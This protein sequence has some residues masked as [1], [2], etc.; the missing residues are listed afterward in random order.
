MIKALIYTRTRFLGPST[1]KQRAWI[2]FVFVF[3]FAQESNGWSSL[4]FDSDQTKILTITNHACWP[5]H[6]TVPLHWYAVYTMCSFKTE[7]WISCY[8]RR[9]ILLFVCSHR[10][11]NPYKYDYQKEPLHR[12]QNIIFTPCWRCELTKHVQKYVLQKQ[13]SQHCITLAFISWAG[14]WPSDFVA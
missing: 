9:Y 1:A 5:L 14:K 4:C 13:S 8:C 2:V 11:F 10:Y 12:V 3:F 6:H 7:T